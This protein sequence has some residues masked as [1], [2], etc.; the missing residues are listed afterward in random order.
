MLQSPFAAL[1]AG[2]Q[3]QVD[4]QF[5]AGVSTAVIRDREVV[6]RFCC[7]HADR[8][9]GEALREDHIFR[10]F[11][12]TKLVTSCAVL[13]RESGSGGLVS[14][15]GDMVRLVQALMPGGP[16]LLK[17]E[18]LALMAGNQLAEGLHV[19]PTCRAIR[20]VCSAWAPRC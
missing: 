14:T 19:S 7:G 8:E 3:S 2:L 17:P 9:A 15:L 4:Q 10:V 12:N 16:T 13:L 1:H 18:K 11:S 6:D 20:A 5:L